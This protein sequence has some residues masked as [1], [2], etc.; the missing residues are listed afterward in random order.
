MLNSTAE[1]ADG[2]PGKPFVGLLGLEL[3]RTGQIRCGDFAPLS[4]Y[5][6]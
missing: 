6:A 2:I 4:Q 5:Q 1:I 3:R